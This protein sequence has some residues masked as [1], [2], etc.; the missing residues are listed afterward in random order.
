MKNEE[1][2]N[3]IKEKHGG[4]TVKDILTIIV[5][6]LIGLGGLVTAWVNLNSNQVRL[7]TRLSMNEKYTTDR[8]EE[9]KSEDA[10]MLVL[11]ERSLNDQ[12]RSNKELQEQVNELE[13]TLSQLYQ[14][15]SRRK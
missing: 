8:V 3:L 11:I 2:H 15:M 5:S 6:V 4:V 10:R 9:L 12:T 13:R 7:E 14:K 1:L